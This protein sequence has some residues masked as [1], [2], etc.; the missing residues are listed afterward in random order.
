MRGE[1]LHPGEERGGEGVRGEEVGP[2]GEPAG[3]LRGQEE[4]DRDRAHVGD[5]RVQ[6]AAPN[7]H[8][9]AAATSQRPRAGDGEA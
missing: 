5:H 4:A 9:Q 1:G 2:E 6:R 3:G 8:A 7:H